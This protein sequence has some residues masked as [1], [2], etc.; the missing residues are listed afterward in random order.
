MGKAA[1]ERI[2]DQQVI[3][4]A[5]RRVAEFQAG[6]AAYQAQRATLSPPRPGRILAELGAARLIDYSHRGGAAR[7]GSVILLIPS[8]INRAT[9]L[10][11]APERS[12]VDFLTRQGLR[13]MVLDWGSPAA[14]EVDF[15]LSDY[16][17]RYLREGL[18]RAVA[19]NGGAPVTVLGYCMGGLLA[20]AAAQ[21]FSAQ[22]ALLVL[23]ATPWDFHCDSRLTARLRANLPALERLIEQEKGLS[24]DTIQGLFYSLDP[25]L[26]VQKYCQVG[27]SLE[28]GGGLDSPALVDFARLE[29]WLNDGVPLVQ[30]VAHETLRDWYGRNTALRLEWRV[31]DTVIDPSQVSQPTLA[32]IPSRDRIVPPASSLALT[33]ALPQAEVLSPEIGHVGMMASPRAQSTVWQPLVKWLEQ[34][35]FM[36]G[37]RL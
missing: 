8:L 4:L 35:G 20:L 16:I 37:R 25:F 13:P 2:F 15:S 34:T 30:R 17:G 27:A 26:V 22:V 29:D 31:C 32:I 24:V 9:I 36:A 14:A 10:D 7:E 12:L 3:I 1:A 18:A 6:V 5:Q 21:L 33:R 23:L 11:L 28:S 19:E